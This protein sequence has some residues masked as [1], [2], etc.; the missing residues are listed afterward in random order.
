MTFVPWAPRPKVD[1]VPEAQDNPPPTTLEKISLV[2]AELRN[3]L[4]PY[5]H[6]PLLLAST[7]QTGIG[8]EAA[9]V[10][11]GCLTSAIYYEAGNEPVSGKRAVAQVIVN[12]WASASFPKTICGVV[13]QGAPRAGCQ[14]TFECDGSL[15]RRPNPES[16]A[17]AQSVAQAALAGSVDFEVGAATHYHADYVVPTW[18]TTMVKLVKIGHHI[19]Y[20]WP[21]AKPGVI[22][23][24]ALPATDP[25]VET[26]PDAV[27]AMSPPA[28]PQVAA[29][30]PHEPPVQAPAIAQPPASVTGAPSTASEIP[31]I[32]IP[33]APGS[34]PTRNQP[35]RRAMP[36]QS[37]RNG[38]I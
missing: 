21:G 20:R 11:L 34:P 32:R 15:A 23:P 8:G 36:D 7:F 6:A 37:L 12:R 5:T 35:P 26:Q 38:P 28:F 9:P 30:D 1:A 19:F 10:A 4:I 33:A 13:Q 14:F 17:Q 18:A 3:A 24:P 16:W 31:L 29:P 2:E 22:A 27:A 25:A